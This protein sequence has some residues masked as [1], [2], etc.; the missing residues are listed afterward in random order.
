MG[1]ESD[2]WV[3]WLGPF[4]G[5]LLATALFLICKLLDCEFLEGRSYIHCLTL[6]AALPDQSFVPAQDSADTGD[7]PDPPALSSS[8]A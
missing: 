2:H 8:A 7:S 4:L 1:F 5:S 3:Y 6:L